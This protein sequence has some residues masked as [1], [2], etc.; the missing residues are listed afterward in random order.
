MKFEGFQEAVA[1]AWTAVLTDPCPLLTL[2]AKLKATTRGLQGWSE[3]K[4]GHVSSQLQLANE[5]LHQLE[6]AQDSRALSTGEVWSHNNLKK[7]SL[8]L[9]SLSRT[10][11]R[12]RY[13]IGRM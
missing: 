4:V 13:R 3:R 10:I 7:H 12:L 5:L 9:A 1:V 11:A 2:T 8:A 6:V